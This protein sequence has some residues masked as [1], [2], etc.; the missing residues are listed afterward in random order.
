MDK[1]GPQYGASS[2]ARGK[3]VVMIISERILAGTVKASLQR[4]LYISGCL[5]CDIVSVKQLGKVSD[6]QQWKYVE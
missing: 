6:S 4:R 3:A 1:Y 5:S 2:P